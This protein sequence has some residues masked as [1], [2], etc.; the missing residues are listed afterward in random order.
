MVLFTE[1]L[2]PFYQQ[3]LFLAVSQ[4][5][6]DE[7]LIVV[8][9]THTAVV[10]RVSVPWVCLTAL[11]DCGATFLTNKSQSR[12]VRTR[13]SRFPLIVRC[14]SFYCIVHT[15]LTPL[16]QQTSFLAVNQYVDAFSNCCCKP[17]LNSPLWLPTQR[18]SVE[19]DT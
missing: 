18:S 4:S 11:R 9:V 17:K 13:F 8:V 2:A 3:T 12:L 15:K 14:L 7:F 6:V 5:Y 10:I 16:F 19:C 1:K